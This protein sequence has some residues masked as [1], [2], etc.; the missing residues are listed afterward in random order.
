MSLSYFDWKYISEVLSAGWTK[1]YNYPNM[2]N[3]T[4]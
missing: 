2:H 3:L 1:T 4:V